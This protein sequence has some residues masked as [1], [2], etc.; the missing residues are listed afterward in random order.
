MDI[1]WTF[2]YW[3]LVDFS[4]FISTVAPPW[5]IDG[6]GRTGYGNEKMFWFWFK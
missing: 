6:I 4:V 2:Y 1:I 3:L 5:L